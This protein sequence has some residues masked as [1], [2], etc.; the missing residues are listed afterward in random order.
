MYKLDYNMH[1]AIIALFYIN[2][3][4]SRKMFNAIVLNT[5]YIGIS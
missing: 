2:M 4:Y 3:M 1:I 5:Q